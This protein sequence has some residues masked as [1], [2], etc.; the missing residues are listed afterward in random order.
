MYLCHS[1]FVPPRLAVLCWEHNTTETLSGDA[2]VCLWPK[3]SHC[4]QGRCAPQSHASIRVDSVLEVALSTVHRL[5]DT[6]AEDVAAGV[7]EAH[8]L[9]VHNGEVGERG[10]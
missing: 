10:V 6:E 7:D 1:W 5:L 2:N 3:L 9:G 4:D 8:A